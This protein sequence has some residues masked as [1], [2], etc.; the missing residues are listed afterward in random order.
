M[1]LDNGETRSKVM[2]LGLQHRVRFLGYHPADVRADLAAIADI[3]V[4]LRRS[5]TNGETSA[6]LIDLLRL[7]VPTIVSDVGSFS[8]YPDSVVCKHRWGLYGLAGL[9][10]AL[11][12]LAE[13]RPRREHWAARRGA[14]FARTIAGRARPTRMKRSSRRPSRDGNGAE[15]TGPRHCRAPRWSPQRNGSM[16]HRETGQLPACGIAR[17]AGASD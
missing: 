10:K 12:K 15:P 3:G 2:E 16:S 4:C 11:R 7:G 6:A 9:T 8:D 5:P 14:T 17:P 1:E 13:D